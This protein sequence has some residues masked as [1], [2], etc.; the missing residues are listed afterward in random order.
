MNTE[1]ESI[2]TELLVAGGVGAV[3]L[4]VVGYVAYTASK[5]PAP[6]NQFYRDPNPTREFVPPG[7]MNAL[8][9]GI[10]HDWHKASSSPRHEKYIAAR[11]GVELEVKGSGPKDSR[12]WYWHVGTFARA[13]EASGTAVSLTTAQLRA[14]EAANSFTSG[15]LPS[16]K[17]FAYKTTIIP[18][19]PGQYSQKITTDDKWH[20][21]YTRDDV[22]EKVRL[23]Y[24]GSDMFVKYRTEYHPL[25]EFMRGGP[26]GWDG[27][28]AWSWSNGLLVKT[29]GVRYKVGHWMLTGETSEVA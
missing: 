17:F 5:P 24:P 6:T 29:D 19:E 18:G 13:K 14:D 2:D 26:E 7:S 25:S 27:A 23:E 12:E 10:P 3:L 9:V 21:F 15:A 4:G 20:D 16:G 22:P 1:D 11:G 28:L 8:G